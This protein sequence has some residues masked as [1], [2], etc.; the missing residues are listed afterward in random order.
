MR[1]PRQ[2]TNSTDCGGE[3]EWADEESY[4]AAQAQHC[5]TA[6]AMGTNGGVAVSQADGGA[7]ASRADGQAGAV[8][9]TAPGLASAVAVA[10]PGGSA[11]SGARS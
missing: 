9:K 1:L 3:W 5:G 4:A 2:D 8:A 7:A 11:T 10:G 6:V